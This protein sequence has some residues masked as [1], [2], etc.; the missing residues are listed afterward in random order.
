MKNIVDIDALFERMDNASMVFVWRA[1]VVFS[2][3]FIGFVLTMVVRDINRP[4]PVEWIEDTYPQGASYCPGD[5]VKYEVGMAIRR[6]AVLAL[7]IATLRD[8][9]LG[10]ASQEDAKLLVERYGL[11]IEGDTLKGARLG[12]V[13]STVLPTERLL[14][15]P[16]AEFVV[17]VGDPGESYVRVLAAVELFRD[18][19]P[20]IRLQRY[21]IRDDCDR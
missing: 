13:W 15:D 1:A 6:P 18:S 21:T 4:S 7:V 8:S 20:A 11:P 16:D 17:P 9:Q 2:F 10:Y 19:E 12:E 3:L 14:W 5:V